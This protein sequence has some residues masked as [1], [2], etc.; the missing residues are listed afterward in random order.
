MIHEPWLVSVP[1][2]PL[3]DARS[4]TPGMS[5]TSLCPYSKWS[6]ATY[7]F[8]FSSKIIWTIDLYASIVQHADVIACQSIYLYAKIKVWIKD[9]S[10]L[11]AKLTQCTFL[12]S[13]NS[14]PL[15]PSPLLS[16]DSCVTW[17]LRALFSSATEDTL[18]RLSWA[19]SAGGDLSPWRPPELVCNVKIVHN[20]KMNVI[21]KSDFK[22]VDFHRNQSISDISL[23]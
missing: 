20:Q 13:P 5:S 16:S 3:A 15:L 12:I 14:Y 2:W 19:R 1:S 11:S 18:D 9:S 21:I 8:F 22:A 10:L 23:S 6:L 4:E 17:R 7:S